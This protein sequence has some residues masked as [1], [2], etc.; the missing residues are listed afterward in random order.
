[1]KVL[2]IKIIL[3]ALIIIIFL[4]THSFAQFN[5]YPKVTRMALD[6]YKGNGFFTL[7]NTGKKE[8]TIVIQVENQWS[9]KIDDGKKEWLKVQTKEIVLKPEE[10]KNIS[11]QVNMNKDMDGEVMAMVYFSKKMEKKKGITL[12]A[13]TGCPVYAYRKGTEK[14]QA[15]MSE[16]KIKKAEKGTY[17]FSM[18]IT[19]KGNNYIFP[20]VYLILDNMKNEGITYSAFSQII[21]VAPGEE[22]TYS[23]PW[24]SKDFKGTLK[25]K[26]IVLYNLKN[27]NKRM[28][29]T[30][31][32][33]IDEN[34][35]MRH[36]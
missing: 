9:N 25:G 8:V 12:H 3:S 19:N 33:I 30:F 18:D 22:R 2:N 26:V 27:V 17:H 20:R 6:S 36:E 5:V 4:V 1:M 16:I 34:G 24:E 14:I 21:P 7:A 11:Y 10:K 15:S 29:R 32:L 31:D 28:N 35:E 23:L 13:R